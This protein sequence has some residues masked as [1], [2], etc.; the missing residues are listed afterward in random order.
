MVQAVGEDLLEGTRKQEKGDSPKT[1]KSEQP[2]TMSLKLQPPKT[3]SLKSEPAQ[4][5]FLKSNSLGKPS[6]KSNPL[7]TIPPKAHP[8]SKISHV[9][10]K[11]VGKSDSALETNG[12]LYQKVCIHRHNR[13]SDRKFNKNP[14]I[15]F[16]RIFN[17]WQGICSCCLASIM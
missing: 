17:K 12:F 3:N 7:D 4:N 5:L 8:G 16:K 11:L 14:M 6:K 10:N 15:F 9:R 13:S 2:K 1:L